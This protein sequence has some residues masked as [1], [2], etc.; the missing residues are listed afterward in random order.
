[1]TL[2]FYRDRIGRDLLPREDEVAFVVD[3][4]L[5]HLAF[6]KSSAC[7]SGVGKLM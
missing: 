4:P 2:F 5:D 6:G 1:M 3:R 7:A